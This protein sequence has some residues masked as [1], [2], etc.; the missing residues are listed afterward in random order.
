MADLTVW[1]FDLNRG[2]ERIKMPRG[3]ALLHVGVQMIEVRERTRSGRWEQPCVWALV[4][5]DQPKV[6]RGLV[7]HGTGHPVY[8]GGNYVG[9]FHMEG[10]LVFHVF[11]H[12]ERPRSVAPDDQQ[13]KGGSE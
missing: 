12:G 7:I 3:A 2:D 10:S 11:D 1:K 13:E 5:P 6:D 4:D 9:T 8:P